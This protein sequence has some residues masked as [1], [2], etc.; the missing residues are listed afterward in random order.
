VRPE[1]FQHPP[2]Q[3]NARVAEF[4]GFQN[5]E[6]LF[7]DKRVRQAIGLSVDRDAINDAEL[8]SSDASFA[9]SL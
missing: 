8:H 1:C 7:H 9:R 2:R 6:H 4:P 3:R 5:P